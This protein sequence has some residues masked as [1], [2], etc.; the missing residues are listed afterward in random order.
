MAILQRYVLVEVIKVFA[1]SVAALTMMV[2][3]G[4]VGREATAQGLPLVPTLRLIPLFL[5]ETLRVTVPMTL[6]LACTT[7]FSRISG[8]NE[9]VAVKALGISPMVLLWPVLIF[10]FLLSLVTVWL[11]DVADSWGRNQIQK[12]VIES[13]DEIAFSMLKSNRR[14]S[15]PTFSINVKDVQ[16]RKLLQVTLIVVGNGTSSKIIITAEDATLRYDRSKEVLKVFL[17]NGVVNV[18]S[19][20]YTFDDVQEQDI[21]VTDASRAQR[22]GIWSNLPLRSLPD[23]IAAAHA[24][25]EQ[26]ED[27]MAAQAAYQMTCGDFDELTSDQWRMHANDQ[28]ELS[29]RYNRLLSVPQRRWA[30]GFACLCFAMVGVPMAILLRNRDFLT[31][32]FVCFLP[33]LIVYYPLMIEGADAA[34]NGNLPTI[35]VW[36]GNIILMFGGAWLLRRVTR[37]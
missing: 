33:I 6:L 4:F 30:G 12:V 20:S 28:L 5:P 15:T 34:K 36:A 19:K 29:S 2:V 9:I 37:Y 14:Y 22:D 31:S 32:F 7:V 35:A 21:P 18:G 25:A 17:H 27:L 23:A 13:V 1:V 11:N 24:Q 16:D 3:L 26:H 10:A 8:A